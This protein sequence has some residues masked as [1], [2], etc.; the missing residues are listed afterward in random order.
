MDIAR[1]ILDP[2]SVKFH[3]AL[4][5]LIFATEKAGRNAEA[6][7]LADESVRLARQNFGPEHGKTLNAEINR[8]GVYRQQ[9]SFQ[10]V[11][12]VYLRVISPVRRSFGTNDMLTVYM[13]CV[14]WL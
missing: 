2:K 5:H 12:A 1:Q 8:A 3:T 10:D 13:E 7:K 4:N 14:L 9:G 11:V 6:E